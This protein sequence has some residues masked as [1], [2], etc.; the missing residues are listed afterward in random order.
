MGLGLAMAAC[1]AIFVIVGFM[2]FQARFAAK[3]WR[4]VIANGD[5]EALDQLLDDTFEAWRRERP[6]RGT[7]P[8][9]WRALHTAA[10]VA[11]DH[12]RIRVSILAEPDVQVVAGERV[13]VSSAQVVARRAAVRMVERLMYEV[14][15]VSFANAQVDV[16]TE[17]RS[18]DGP[19]LSRCL[20]TTRVTRDQAAYADWEEA[21]ADTILG[22]WDTRQAHGDDW[23]DPDADAIIHAWTAEA[24]RAAEDA[25]K[26]TTNTTA[27]PH[28]VAGDAVGDAARDFGDASKDE[29]A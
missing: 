13:E 3:H 21:E 16:L 2:V 24:L 14:P 29:Q 1:L 4:R 9:D 26:P 8:A 11:A 27:A 12:E 5:R 7:P 25:I 28:D 22:E 23:P 19:T 20:L 18:P 10:L 17:Y 6:R 15:H